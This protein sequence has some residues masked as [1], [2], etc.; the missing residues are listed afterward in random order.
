MLNHLT[1]SERAARD[2]FLSDDYFGDCA[3]NATNIDGLVTTFSFLVIAS[4]LC[5]AAIAAV[6]VLV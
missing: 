4:A 3:D 5:S 2:A 6:I 1:I